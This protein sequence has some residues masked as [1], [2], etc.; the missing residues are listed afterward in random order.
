MGLFSFLFDRNDYTYVPPPK[1][2]EKPEGF[3]DLYNNMNLDVFQK[4]G[5]PFLT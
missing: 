5:R 3:P 1:K 2:E 4:D